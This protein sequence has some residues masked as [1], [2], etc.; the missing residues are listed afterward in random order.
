MKENTE[1]KID[2]Y[3]RYIKVDIREITGMLRDLD[4]LLDDL[5]EMELVHVQEL[6]NHSQISDVDDFVFRKMKERKKKEKE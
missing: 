1:T 6:L 2:K 3:R 4:D 5:T